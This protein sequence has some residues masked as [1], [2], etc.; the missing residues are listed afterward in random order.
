MDNTLKTKYKDAVR[1][2]LVIFLTAQPLLDIYMN[3]FDDKIS[4]FGVS[5]A[6]V[7][8]FGL[9]F[10]LLVAVVCHEW[11][12]KATVALLIYGGA[13]VVYTVFHHVNAVTF[14]VEL[15]TAR[16]HL[17]EELFYLVRM[18]V[19]IALMYIIYVVRLRYR[20][21]K[22][23]VVWSAFTISFVIIAT[24]LLKIGFVAYQLE[25]ITVGG[26]MANWFFGSPEGTVWWEL[27]CRGFFQATNQLSGVAVLLTPVLSYVCFREKKPFYWVVMLMHLIAMINL[28]SRI[29]SIGGPAVFAVMVVIH[30]AEKLIHKEIK[31]QKLV[32]G[33]A[34]FVVL[35]AV[36]ALVF[37]VHSP[38][39]M[40]A[41]E[42]GV[43]DDFISGS[44]PDSEG[45]PSNGTTEKLP[46]TQEDTSELPGFS[47]NPEKDP[48]SRPD[49]TKEKMI[50]YVEKHY[51]T[52][53]VQYLYINEAYPYT[54]DPEFWYHLIKE[55]PLSRRY[56]NRN[57]RGYI[58]DRVF[59]RDNR[60]SNELL[61]ISYTRS[62]SLI[63]PERDI[64]T[65]LDS[66]G[67]VGTALFIGPYFVVL[68]MGIWRFFAKWKE[69]LYLGK[70]VFLI[71]G[72]LGVVIA[73]FSGHIMDEIFPSLYLSC[74]VGV[75]LSTFSK[76]A[77]NGMSETSK[78]DS[79][80]IGKDGE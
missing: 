18:C 61:G 74:F 75:L 53:G 44:Q 13:V 21:V 77:E 58:F 64:E 14:S 8:R 36:L 66:L 27:S 49:L 55:V 65:H 22:T 5:L 52:A 17:V 60:F 38:M 68:L 43:F 48:P 47:S 62:S 35:C 46:E 16:Y 73:Y 72:G 63:W 57:L 29:A 31:L 79:Q 20:D 80:A 24:N 45:G 1:R 37:F 26:T 15:A 51:P 71:T 67:I 25:D 33:N 9:V 41:A 40:R 34:V 50:A 69:N 12:R 42:G 78:E 3:F 4:L 54:E 28:S 11:K 76:N 59:E 30:L 23:I 2:L 10:V 7:L 19:P 70:C 32:N 39:S 56:G 6:T